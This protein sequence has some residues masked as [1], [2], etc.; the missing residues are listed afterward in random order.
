MELIDELGLPSPRR[1]FLELLAEAPSN[2]KDKGTGADIY[3][4]YAEPASL[5]AQQVGNV[6]AELL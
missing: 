4:R 3:R 2:L 5:S 1:E 6:E